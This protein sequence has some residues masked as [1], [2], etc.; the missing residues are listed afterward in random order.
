MKVVD[1]DGVSYLQGFESKAVTMDVLERWKS[2][3]RHVF[4]SGY[5]ARRQHRK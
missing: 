3:S 1:D 2:R 5:L 4:W